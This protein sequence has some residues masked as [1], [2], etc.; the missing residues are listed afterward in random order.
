[1]YMVFWF[2]L[3][4]LEA[5]LPILVQSSVYVFGVRRTIGMGIYRELINKKCIKNMV[6]ELSLPHTLHY[7]KIMKN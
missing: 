4:V 6:T 3:G 5:V 1:M 2:K 7:I